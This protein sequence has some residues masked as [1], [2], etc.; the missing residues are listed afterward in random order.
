[1]RLLILVLLALAPVIAHADPLIAREQQEVVKIFDL[2]TSKLALSPIVDCT[3]S[4]E[5]D[6]I[7]SNNG[8]GKEV[9]FQP[10]ELLS[11]QQALDPTGEHAEMFCN[12][13]E[14][15]ER[16]KRAQLLAYDRN[17]VI[18]VESI[19]YSYPLF[20]HN[21]E[22]AIVYSLIEG[23][24]L[25]RSPKEKQYMAEGI[26]RQIV[27]RKQKGVWTYKISELSNYY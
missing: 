27:L 9:A 24:L 7:T 15:A 17:E 14:R 11:I 20:S 10:R 2:L 21:F 6:K 12:R 25:R 22:R 19:G 13:A 18:E 1:M 3:F 8:N 16:D 5:W 23:Q 26:Y 4:R